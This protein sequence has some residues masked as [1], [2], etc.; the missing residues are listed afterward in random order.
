MVA[1]T[2]AVQFHARQT[3][4][5]VAVHYAGAVISYG[6]LAQRS[7]AAAGMLQARG[8]GKGDVV[9]LL[10]KNSAAFIELALAVSQAGAVLLP[11]NFRLAQK[12]VA[13]ILEHAGAR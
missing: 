11:I 7:A 9:A 10:M 12:E 6:E 1:L 5:R 3:P 4:N 8:I 13:F 2:S